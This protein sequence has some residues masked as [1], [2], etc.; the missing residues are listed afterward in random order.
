[1]KN[2]DAIIIGQ[3][4]AGTALAW[5]LRWAGQRVLVIDRE[6]PVTASRVAAGL[7]TPITGRRMVNAWQYDELWPVAQQFYARVE[8]ETGV[9][10]FHEQPMVRLFRSSEAR[11]HFESTRKLARTA[12]TAV[13]SQLHS[14]AGASAWMNTRDANDTDVDLDS[15]RSEHGGFTMTGGR[16]DV[17]TYLR[18][19]R[20]VFIADGAYQRANIDV[21]NDIELT[22]TGVVVTPLKLTARRLIF[23]QGFGGVENPYF[24][25]LPFLPAKGEMLTVDVP[26]LSEVHVVHREVWLAPAPTGGY[27]VGATYD[28]RRLDETPTSAGR[29]ELC[30]KLDHLLHRPYTVTDHVA[31]VRPAMHDQRP[32]LGIHPQ[33]PQLACFNGLGSK[34]CL[35]APYF[36]EQLTRH[37]LD[38]TAIE[39]VVQLRNRKRRT[40]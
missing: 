33:H 21:A 20:A 9:T 4:L 16:L 8:S 28:S 26:Q 38:G 22:A 30:G 13:P 34:G 15:Y 19:S 32:L 35:W 17:A 1:M 2:V 18:A 3:G 25:S 10:C 14:L 31:A 11:E 39:P 37:L 5:Q 27:R 29:A 7:I 23:C 24:R 12:G 40:T 36:A 6:R